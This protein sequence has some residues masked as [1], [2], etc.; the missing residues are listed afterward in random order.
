MTTRATK[1]RIGRRAALRGLMSGAAVAVA[2]PR[3]DAMLNLHGTAF[4]AGGA[5][6]RR[7]GVWT[8][9]NGVH[10]K[11]WVPAQ[12]GATWELSE[13]LAPL[14]K[15][16]ADMTVVSGTRVPH[17]PGR[18][19]AA[20]NTQLMTAMPTQYAGG[21]Q[22]A[23]TAK[24]PSIDQLVAAQIGKETDFK[25]IEVGI[26]KNEAPERGTSFHWWSHNGPNSPNPCTYD[27]A[28]LFSRLFAK[29]PGAGA[30]TQ[31]DDAGAIAAKLRK[32][33]LD[34]VLEDARDLDAALGAADRMRLQQ[35][36][37][38]IRAVE[39]RVGAIARGESPPAAACG[40]PSMPDAA[41]VGKAESYDLRG[42]AINKTMAELVA[43]ALAC[44]LT[45]VF[46][47]EHTQPGSHITIP[48]I[49][50]TYEY[51][52]LTHNDWAGVKVQSAIKLFMGELSV[53]IETLRGYREGAGSLLDSCAIMASTD[54]AQGDNHGVDDYPILVFGRAGGLKAGILFRS[55]TKET[56]CL[57][58]YT[59]AKAV[60]AELGPWGEGEGRCTA[61]LGALLP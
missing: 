28:A 29:P 52:G 24:G 61:P 1:T 58:P 30:T 12:T 2:L 5:L 39:K 36:L 37:D 57:V 41:L 53:L 46:T 26:D 43:L 6:P 47:F 13:E 17:G 59:L 35:H 16:K 18:G 31:G 27:C 40:K 42:K 32:S 11:R 14:A 4:A 3:L 19:H 15:V 51:H 23:A 10:L 20:P 48:S 34:A 55:A 7:F 38:A 44:D 50:V 22:S 54:C 9:A 8:W 25:S 33:V 45:R 49:G 60:G 21:N 56:A